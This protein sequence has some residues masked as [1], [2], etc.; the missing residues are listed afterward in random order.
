[1]I[2]FLLAVGAFWGDA[3]GAGHF[4]NPVGILLLL[5]TGFIWF[6]WGTIR[7]G[8]LSAKGESDLPIIRLASTI[9]RGMEGL[10]HPPRP[11]RSS[12]P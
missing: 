9:I 2:A 7:D 6:A 11:R 12:S 10:K 5:L 3:L 8:F 4:M 1:M